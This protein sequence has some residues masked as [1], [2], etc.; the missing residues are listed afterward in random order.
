MGENILGSGFSFNIELRLGAGAFV[1]GEG[2]ALM[3]SIEGRRGMPRNKIYRTAER[4]LFD[5]PTIINNVET[6]ANV[7]HIYLHGADWFAGIGTSKSTGTKVFSVV[8][9]VKNAGL[10]E[11]SMGTSLTE[12]IYDISSGIRNDRRIKAVQK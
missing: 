3:E 11:V 4:G 5:K 12:I 8:G 10:V 7:H 9:K 6:L 1:C 2:T